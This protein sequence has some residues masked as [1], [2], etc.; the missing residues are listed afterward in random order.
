MYKDVVEVLLDRFSEFK[1]TEYYDSANSD[2]AYVVWGGFGRFVT[3]YMRNL[4]ADR[5]DNDMLVARV[6]EFAN[7]L[8]DSDDP[9]T[10]N[11]VVVELFENFFMYRKILELA[12]RKLKKKHLTWLERQGT[13]LRTSDTD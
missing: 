12:R 11:I 3:T 13:W 2:L 1:E 5:L 10:Q 8:M 9:E 6:F 7:E 4:P